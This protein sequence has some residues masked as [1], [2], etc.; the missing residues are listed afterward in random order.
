MEHDKTTCEQ[1][2]FVIEYLESHHGTDACDAEFH[3]EFHERFGGKFEHKNFGAQPVFKAQRLLARMAK[4]G[5][6]E[7]VIVG[8]SYAQAE[9][10]FPRWV[11]VYYLNN[12]HDNQA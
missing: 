1:E 3:A 4:N 5:I 7:R 2:L 10:G 12:D 6:L 9:P 8:M 11:Y